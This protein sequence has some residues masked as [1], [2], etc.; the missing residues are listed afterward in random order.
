MRTNPR[1]DRYHRI[2]A[3]DDRDL[4]SADA[5]AVAVSWSVVDE[6]T[7][8]HVLYMLN[9][10]AGQDSPTLRGLYERT[11]PQAQQRARRTLGPYR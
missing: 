3:A 10:A 6:T 8:R 1:P 4:L 2:A 5:L 7:K 11:S 9:D